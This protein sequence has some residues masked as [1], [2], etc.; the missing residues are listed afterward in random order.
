[1]KMWA[2]RFEGE[3]DKS[4]DDF[5]SS[6]RFDRRL[7]AYD[8][9][10]SEAHVKMLKKQGIIPGEDADRCLA[11]LETLK[12]EVLSGKY[13][14]Q[15]G[16][17]DIHMA[18]EAIL[19][20]RIG[21]AAKKIHTARSRNDQV[22]LDM[23]MYTKD[24]IQGFLSQIGHLCGTLKEIALAHTETIL[25]GYTHLQRAQPISLAHHLC[26][27]IEM[28]SRDRSRLADCYKRMNTLPL[29]SGALACSTFDIDREYVAQLLNFDG[30]SQNSLDS[31]SDRDYLLELLSALSILMMHLSRFC[32]EVILWSTEEFGYLI[33]SDQFSTGS[34]M[35]PQKKNPDMAELIR[36]K[37]GRVYGSLMGL[38]TVMK[39]IPLAY[40]K[41]MQEDKECAFD[42]MDTVSACLDIFDK[43]IASASF[44]EE[45][46]LSAAVNSFVNATDMAEYLVK[47]GCPF[48]DAHFVVG[49]LVKKCIQEGKYLSGLTMEELK[50]ASNYFESDV[51]EVLN[52]ETSVHVKKMTGSPNPQ[53][54]REYLENRD[55]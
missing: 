35:M 30:V 10:G 40:N 43:M 6:L 39:G 42:A 23:K 44:C 27:Y 20:E 17:E 5:N 32:E 38:L 21:N 13:I 34:S 48:R 1:M 3:T 8:V 36:G 49:G 7:L 41:D 51:F 28:F 22:A 29:G 26:A 16:Y 45:K 24:R 37:T 46:M 33:L 14:I 50:A 25:P 55:F 15:T 47:K 12:D 18:V 53:V 9:E 2:G 19:T 11:A 4:A 31:V 54:V 52:V